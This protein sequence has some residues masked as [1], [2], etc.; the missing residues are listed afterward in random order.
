MWFTT[1]L[2]RWIQGE[3]PPTLTRTG[4][5]R[6]LTELIY[7]EIAARKEP[8]GPR[9]PNGSSPSH[10]RVDLALKLLKSLRRLG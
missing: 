9:Q 1:E 7:G 8:P 2:C 5:R 10:G 3:E 6:V 4:L